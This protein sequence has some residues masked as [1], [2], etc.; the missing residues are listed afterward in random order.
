MNEGDIM[1]KIS[2]IESIC[3]MEKAYTPEVSNCGM[4]LTVPHR[5]ISPIELDSG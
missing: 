1:A 4:K 5:S 3:T 2:A